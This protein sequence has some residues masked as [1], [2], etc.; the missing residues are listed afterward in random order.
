MK[1]LQDFGTRK[2]PP[3]EDK[4]ATLGFEP[5]ARNVIFCPQGYC[6]KCLEPM[7]IKGQNKNTIKVYTNEGIDYW[8]E[9]C[10]RKYEDDDICLRYNRLNKKKKKQLRRFIK[11]N[12]KND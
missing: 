9:Q 10:V 5:A 1:T 8:C 12:K 3:E 11:R 2:L 7:G 6:P 4:T